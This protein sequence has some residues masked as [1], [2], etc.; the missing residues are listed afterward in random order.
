M[1]RLARFMQGRYGIDKLFYF[2]CGTAIVLSFVNIFTR[3]WIVQIITYLL[4]IYAFFRILSR[5]TEKRRAENMKFCNIWDKIAGKFRLLKRMWKDRKTHCYVKCSQ[6]K[7]VL[8]LPK[9][10][11][12]HTVKCP[13][14]SSSFQVK[15]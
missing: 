12:I 4:M 3:S 9:K 7:K 14:C 2:I 6:C 15:I 11:G 13:N 5:K 10:K 1:Y 8:R